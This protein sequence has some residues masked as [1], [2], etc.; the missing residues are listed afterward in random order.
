VKQEGQNLKKHLKQM[1][2]L[3]R[4]AVLIGL[5]GCTAM[6]PAGSAGG[7]EGFSFIVTADIVGFVEPGY[8][9]PQYF[10]GT[11][12]AIRDVGKGAFMASPGDINPP[13]HVHRTIRNV[14][15]D[16]YPWYPV[17]GNHDAEEPEYMAWLRNW[18]R[19]EIPGMVRK[20]PVNGEE[21]TYSF[22]VGNAH[23]VAINQYY[24]GASDAAADADVA[25]PLYN[26]L[27]NDLTA[28]RKP[29]VFVLGHEPLVSIP[30]ADN[31]RHR[32]V[33]DSLDA[34]PENSHRFQ[35][36]LRQHKVTA[37][38][39]GHTHGFSYAKINGVWQLDAGH[40]GGIGDKGAR[41]TFLKIH[42]GSRGCRVEAYRA[43]PNG[44]NYTLAHTVALD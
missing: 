29:F 27:K 43:D 26:W 33:G 40:A 41:S 24:D 4:L 30:D 34:Y 10:L 3:C 44:Q 25:E 11:C 7:E 18:G 35:Q 42:V 37:Y 39:C 22:D 8:E 9:T 31:G 15:G 19:R 16:D 21:T 6:G 17:V 2:A 20:G 1:L 5:A 28:N 32:H 13:P 36:L 23:F 12:E 14:L 38:I